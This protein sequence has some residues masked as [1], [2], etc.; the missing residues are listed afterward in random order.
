M[1]KMLQLL[2][3]AA[4]EV[5]PEEIQAA[6][7]AMLANQV[8]AKAAHTVIDKNAPASVTDYAPLVNHTGAVTGDAYLN[9]VTATLNLSTDHLADVTANA[10]EIAAQAAYQAQLDAYD[11]DTTDRHRNAEVEDNYALSVADG[12]RDA[13]A[14]DPS[15]ALADIAAAQ[16]VVDAAQPILM[17]LLILVQSLQLILIL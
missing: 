4:N 16:A 17:L 3:A 7:D 10:A 9:G 6:R 13:Y 5:T 8:V 2:V 15:L 12:V 1:L 11:A 14:A